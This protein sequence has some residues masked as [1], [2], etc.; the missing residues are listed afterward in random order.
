MYIIHMELTLWHASAILALET[1]AGRSQV[2]DHLVLHGKSQ[3][4]MNY[5]VS[6]QSIRSH[7]DIPLPFIPLSPIGAMCAIPFAQNL[8][9]LSCGCHMVSRPVSILTHT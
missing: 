2:L 3:V 5:V 8:L 6:L 9:S 1:Q 4:S 7:Y